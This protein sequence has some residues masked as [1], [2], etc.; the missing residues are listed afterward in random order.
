MPGVT[1]AL[2]GKKA[3]LSLAGEL[4]KG[5]VEGEVGRHFFRRDETSVN[6][7]T[8]AKHPE[9]VQGVS[10]ALLVADHALLL[11]E[12]VDRDL[13]TLILAAA[14]SGI[15]SG[16]ILVEK[17][18]LVESVRP[19]LA[20]TGLAGWPVLTGEQT[21]PALLREA[22]LEL[23]AG[24]QDGATRV[25]VEQAFPV[26]G[27]GTV[28]LGVVTHGEVKKNQ[29]LEHAPAGQSAT[30]RSIQV[31]SHDVDVATGGQ[32]VGLALRG[33]EPES[34]SRG[35]ILCEP[36]AVTTHEPETALLWDVQVPRFHG[37]G[38]KGERALHV[39]AGLQFLP[40]RT[41]EATAVDAGASGSVRVRLEAPL[42]AGDKDRFLLW[43]LNHDGLRLVAS[44]RWPGE[45]HENSGG[46]PS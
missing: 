43:D 14:A 6:L 28:I 21:Q 4:G 25:A 45:S 32:R 12:E 7:V 8:P 40:V 37:P 9:R 1:V 19:L 27:L 42:V 39:G 16:W 46:K 34:F 22:L 13:G 18:E 20:D 35:H 31:H 24:G 36:G 41:D 33:V 5:D 11:V 15:S 26:K 23:P 3:A 44:A 38:L 2:L 17:E 10:Q 29:R 30:V